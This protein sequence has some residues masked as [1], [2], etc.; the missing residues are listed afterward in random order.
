MMN[1]KWYKEKNFVHIR[2][3]GPVDREM[4]LNAFDQAISGDQ[5]EPGMGRLWDFRDVDLSGLKSDTIRGLT[6]Y[7][8]KHPAGIN[9]VKVAFL[10]ESDL[11][12]G[13]TNMFKFASEAAT[14]I[15]LFRSFEDAESWLLPD[16]GAGKSPNFFTLN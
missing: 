12:Y 14:S 16:E 5:H 4:L 9:D 6:K 11:E 3:T 10:T 1:I 13:L 8:Q 15:R 2:L 7:T